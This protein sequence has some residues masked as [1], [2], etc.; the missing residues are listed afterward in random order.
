MRSVVGL[1]A[2]IVMA[3]AASHAWSG[4]RRLDDR[5]RDAQWVEDNGQG[6]RI[7]QWSGGYLVLTMAYPACRRTCSTTT[8]ALKEIQKSFDRSG[9]QAEFVV[10]SYESDRDTPA[11]WARYRRSRNLTRSNWHFLTGKAE[12]TR[13]LARMLDLAFWNYDEHV[14]HDFRIIVFGPDGRFVRE[15]GWLDLRQLDALLASR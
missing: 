14:I 13:H 6:A 4:D 1:V 15:V 8:L 2:A 10:I 7:S 3:S 11:D 9:R 5:I 12:D